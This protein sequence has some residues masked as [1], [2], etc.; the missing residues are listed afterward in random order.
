MSTTTN[1]NDESTEDASDQKKKKEQ[2]SSI[3]T[4][5]LNSFGIP[6]LEVLIGPKQR[7]YRYHALFLASYSMYVDTILS[8]PMTSAAAAATNSDDERPLRRIVFEDIEED[9]WEI[10]ISYLEPSSRFDPVKLADLERILPFYDKYQFVDGISLCDSAISYNLQTK[11]YTPLDGY[12]TFRPERFVPIA[13][14]AYHLNLPLSKKH[15]IAWASEV[16]KTMTPNSEDTITKLLPLVEN[17][18]TVLISLVKT[19]RGRH[20]T[21]MTMDEMRVLTQSESFAR[22]VLLKTKQIE[23]LEQVLRDLHG[24]GHLPCSERGD[25]CS[26]CIYHII[27]QQRESDRT[28]CKTGTK[29]TSWSG[30]YLFE[31]ATT[32]TTT[33]TKCYLINP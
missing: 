8:S 16:L 7:I 17:D 2:S 10:M 11:H 32:T 27:W 6:D 20:Y 1:D 14:L 23:D 3:S 22:D 30:N 33:T 25:T 26:K 15:A 12:E 29:W 5:R 19:I 9:T 31:C 21:D 13:V 28:L 24:K 18:D 4:R